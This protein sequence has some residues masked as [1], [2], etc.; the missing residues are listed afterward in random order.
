M[1]LF[2]SSRQNDPVYFIS[3]LQAEAR[4]LWAWLF[5]GFCVF[6]I[7]GWY[8]FT[9]KLL[10]K[11]PPSRLID[12]LFEFGPLGT[13]LLLA[14]NAVLITLLITTVQ[15]FIYEGLK[16]C[17]TLPLWAVG[18]FVFY[19]LGKPLFSDEAP[20]SQQTSP[21]SN[22]MSSP[23][24]HQPE[25]EPNYSESSHPPLASAS[26]PSRIWAVVDTPLIFCIGYDPDSRSLIVRRSSA[27][28]YLTFVYENV[29]RSVFDRFL[30]FND[31]DFYYNSFISSSYHFW[32]AHDS[33]FVDIPSPPTSSST[34]S[35]QPSPLPEPPP[36]PVPRPE[37][38][39]P[40]RTVVPPHPQNR[41]IPLHS[42]DSSA[43]SHWG[44]DVYSQRLF[45]RMRDSGILYAYYDVPY[46]VALDLRYAPSVG[47][48]YNASIKG[49]YR[50]R[51]HGYKE[52]TNDPPLS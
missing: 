6:W 5:V 48:Y 33:T 27:Y 25:P 15:L 16:A 7:A 11:L 42:T 51:N 18:I 37:P 32:V 29:P 41:S 40:P 24:T 14:F 31:T 34:P 35:P 30:R 28:L 17:V 20:A 23:A 21:P 44:Y 13:L 9:C 49:K 22:S 38:V 3:W 10:S 26:S 36:E 12:I 39:S 1:S 8:L 45:L 19:H 46:E 52:L 2:L 47:Q 4:P 50:S 43:I